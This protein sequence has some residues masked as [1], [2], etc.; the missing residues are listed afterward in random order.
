[1]DKKSFKEFEEWAEKNVRPRLPDGFRE[2]KAEFEQVTKHSGTYN[3]MFIRPAGEDVSCIVN[4]DQFYSAY[5]DGEEEE[6]I[7]DDM[8]KVITM[9]PPMKLGDK[10]MILDYKQAKKNLFIRISSREAGGRSYEG[11]PVYEKDEFVITY[12]LKIDFGDQNYGSV[13]IDNSMLRYYGI[14]REQLH[15]DAM[16]NS[17]K[18]FPACYDSCA[19]IMD[20]FGQGEMR[21]AIDKIPEYIREM[22]IVS[23]AYS[24]AGSAVLFYP[25]TLEAISA[26][27]GG[28]FYVLP[29]SELS[30][31]A[32]PV[33][34]EEFLEAYLDFICHT[35]SPSN[36]GYVLSHNLYRYDS[37]EKKF[38]VAVQAK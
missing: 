30:S 10:N 34:H 27:L 20:R 21:D 1:M 3:G 13:I 25:S 6:K 28:D 35:Y 9:K 29:Y 17:M 8:V 38:C 7:L 16:A 11:Y 37:A 31:I 36:D 23:D 18:L 4:M 14:T 33:R 2:C 24:K 19:E 26:K 5:L 12:N 32:F 22:L 15:K